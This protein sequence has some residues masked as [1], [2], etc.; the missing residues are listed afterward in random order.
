M[1]E[2]VRVCGRLM[3]GECNFSKCSIMCS[4]ARPAGKEP[5]KYTFNFTCIFSLTDSLF[6]SGYWP[7]L[8]MLRRIR[9][10]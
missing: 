5:F 10:N 3:V 7:S 1:L 9:V 8:H 2:C 6:N 4:A